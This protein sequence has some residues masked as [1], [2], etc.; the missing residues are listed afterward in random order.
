M[1]FGADVM[2]ENTAENQRGRPFVKG[3]SGN[4]AGKPKGARHRATV[5]AEALFDGE[6]EALTRKAI[7]L[8]KA[9]DTLALRLCLERVLSPRKGRPVVFDLPVINKPAD[10][11]AALGALVNAVARGSLTPDEGAAVAGLLEAKRRGLE[12]VEL[13]QRIAALEQRATK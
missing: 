13:E 5:A 3:R 11:V 7:E 9:G 12:T 10:V 4:P 6:A 8:A 2:A 1:C